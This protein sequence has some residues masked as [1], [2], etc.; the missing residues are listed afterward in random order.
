VT[1]SAL[2]PRAPEE[3][4]SGIEIRKRA[5]RAVAVVGLRG[6][7]IRLL[8]IAALVAL[9]RMLTPRD[10]G[11]VA[12][13]LVIVGVLTLLTDAGIAA[14]LIRGR[15]APDRRDVEAFFAFQLGLSVLLTAVVAVAALPFGTAGEVAAV[16]A[17]SLPLAA[18]RAP[19]VVLLER[20]LDYRPIFFADLA[21]TIAYYG[22]ALATVSA[23]W[24][25]WGLAI[26]AIPRAAVGSAVIVAMTPERILRPRPDAAR[27]RRLLG[28]GL[29]VQ[30][31]AAVSL[32]RDHGLNLGVA[33]ISGFAVLGVWSF[34]YR[35]LQIPY[36]LFT[37][38]WRVSFPAMARLA[39]A[40]EDLRPVVERSVALAAVATGAIL[41]PLVA[42]TPAL[43][44]VVLGE[45]WNGVADVVP[46]PCLGLVIGAPISV[47]AAGYLYAVGDAATPLRATL[48]HT[49]AW[50]AVAFILLPVVGAAAVGI[51]WLASALVDAAVL[52]RATARRSG[53]DVVRPLLAPTALFLGA[54][55][56][57][58]A[59]ASSAEAGLGVAVA[60]G[61][62]A[63][64]VYLAGIVLVK[65]SV[66]FELWALAGSAVRRAPTGV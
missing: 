24:G 39:G 50:L 46:W 28:F 11:L 60:A 7:L 38:L 21:E 17:L 22:F 51:G 8:Q 12:F 63:A 16:M 42:A 31:V 64:A 36:I 58:W 49:C 65:R 23:G 1:G 15:E 54:G 19:G 25:V 14:S 37:A 61:A 13:G 48:L 59:I 33:A 53:A 43:V 26:A 32:V 55:G 4:L 41:T 44:P 30:A 47:A 35:I 10:F 34:A 2:P 9:A 3:P 29:K 56:A 66:V 5:A 27:L 45:K 20:R 62:L 40:G 18:L 52:G 6:V 57:G